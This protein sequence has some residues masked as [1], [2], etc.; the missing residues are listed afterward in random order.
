MMVLTVT[1]FEILCGVCAVIL[2]HLAA[3]GTLRR[4]RIAGIRVP[5]TLASDPAW[6]AGHRAGRSAAVVLTGMTVAA[7][8]VLGAAGG[9]DLDQGVD[10]TV[11]IFLVII[12]GLVYGSALPVIANRAAK[13]V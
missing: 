12:W 2:C 10:M 9:F 4:N 8:V 6:C 11:A 7:A 5:S 1:V 13:R 3:R